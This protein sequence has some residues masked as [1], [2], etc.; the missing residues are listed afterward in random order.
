[1]VVLAVVATSGGGLAACTKKK[2][3]DDREATPA[4]VFRAA[5]V[6]PATLDP[7]KARTVDELI[8]I[9]QLYD[10]L[11]AYDPDTLEPVP[12]VAASW[13]ASEDQQHWDFTL[14]ADAR[15]SDGSPITSTDVKATLERI[16]R[17]DSGSSVGDL[18]ELV[19]GYRAVAVDGSATELAGVLAPSPSVVHVDLDAPWSSLPSALANPAFGVVP[20]AIA[21][22]SAFPEE[23]P[24]TN[25][26]FRITARSPGRLS[27]SAAPGAGVAARSGRL[28]FRFFDDR[29]GSYAALAS[30]DADWSQVPPDQ[31]AEAVKRFGP[32]LFRPYVAELFYA[33]NLRNPKFAD[34][35]FREA[36]VRAVDVAGIIQEAYAETVQPMDGLVASGLAAH[37]PGACGDRCAFDPERSKALLAEITSSGGVVPD[38]QL[39]FD[40]DPTQT[41]VATAIQ[42]DLASV[43]ITA[44]LR[45]KPL[46]EYQQFAVT[47]EQELFRLGWIAPYPSADAI[48]TPL[49]L[50]GFPNNLTGFTSAP[51]DDLLRA[52]RATA[53]AAVRTDH[54]QQAEQAILAELPIVPIAQ[55]EIQ[56]AA[57]KRV[58]GLRVTSFGTFDARRVTVDA[59][60]DDS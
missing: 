48:L 22:A 21:D 51:V 31:H 30:G 55:F 25:G 16:A 14:R 36:V 41:A 45:S 37:R 15:F 32:S 17:K 29:A 18:L 13:T 12:S 34:A 60:S 8:V 24:V 53:D 47:G 20:K 39:D 10:S 6:R 56:S 1:V 7:A 50:T 46:A 33:F 38:L 11:A 2:G 49:F 43:G 3:G 35:R 40:D 57:A 19:A 28:E 5:V 54:Y 9:D 59:S 4:P 52:A 23:A 42:G 27:L 44:G 26:P 58:G